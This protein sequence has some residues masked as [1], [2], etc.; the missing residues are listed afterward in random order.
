MLSPFAWSAVLAVLGAIV[1]SFIAALVMRWPQGRSVT[2]GRSACDACGRT[3]TARD[4]LPLISM[5]L[6]NGRCRY[7][8]ARITLL[9]AGLEMAGLIV[10]ASAG[11]VAGDQR[12]IAGAF[13]GW[14]LLAIASL[15]WRTFWLPDELTGTLAIMGFAE[16]AT[17][18]GPLLSDRLVGGAAGFGMLWL[19]AFAYRNVRKRE[20]M[21]GG[22]PKLM[23]AI[24]LWLGWRMLAPVLLLASLGGLGIVL[25]AKLIGRPMTRTTALPLGTML[26][27]AA[28]PTW[29]A[30]VGWT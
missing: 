30:M 12:A 11:W 13:F 22:D 10:G 15:D 2:H 27:I 8:G 1:G 28:Y 26:A 25:V 5:F 6:L 24:G 29:L 3:L 9:H 23:G 18:Q 19:I 20:G 21:G 4:L 16:V 17:Q 14:L 7:C